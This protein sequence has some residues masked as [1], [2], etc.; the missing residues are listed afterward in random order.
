MIQTSLLSLN[1]PT[2][3]DVPA[4]VLSFTSDRG[5]SNVASIPD[6]AGICTVAGRPFSIR[7]PDY[8]FWNEFFSSL[9]KP[10]PT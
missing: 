3:A 5:V 2:V 1:C 6:V 8:G 4:G 10:H 9:V 7:L